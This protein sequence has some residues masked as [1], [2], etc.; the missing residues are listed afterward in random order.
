MNAQEIVQLIGNMGVPIAILFLIWQQNT[1]LQDQLLK[2][3][4]T[5]SEGITKLTDKIDALI[6]GRRNDDEV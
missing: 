3:V 2:L 5:T 6:G 1:K 4:Q